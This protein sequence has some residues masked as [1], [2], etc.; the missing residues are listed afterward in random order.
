[1]IFFPKTK[2]CALTQRYNHPYLWLRLF[3]QFFKKVLLAIARIFF[4]LNFFIADE[5]P[6]IKIP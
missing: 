4:P 6:L 3:N 1:M 5:L 2:I